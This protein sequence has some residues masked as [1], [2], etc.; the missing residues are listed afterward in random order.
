ML[1]GDAMNNI[2]RLNG[3]IEQIEGLIGETK[4]QIANGDCWLDAELNSL[5]RLLH[6]FRK[7]LVMVEYKNS[8]DSPECHPS[9]V[10]LGMSGGCI[11][12]GSEEFCY[13]TRTEL[14]TIN[15]IAVSVEF[16]EFSYILTD[17]RRLEK[18]IQQPQFNTSVVS[19]GFVEMQKSKSVFN[20][21]QKDTAYKVKYR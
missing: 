6:D 3:F 9:R 8:N 13:A 7:Q 17:M 5:E 15:T 4:Q 12:G 10:L 2:D 19:H 16:G 1:L 18:N 20:L 21:M 11:L 14:M